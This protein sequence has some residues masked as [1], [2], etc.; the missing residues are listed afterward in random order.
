MVAAFQRV[1]AVSNDESVW[2]LIRG[3]LRSK[4]T[5]REDRASRRPR[6]IAWRLR[7]HFP[8]RVQLGP[9]PVSAG[10]K[11]KLD[12]W[13][14]ARVADRDQRR[15]RSPSSVKEGQNGPVRPLPRRRADK[16]RNLSWR[17]ASTR[18]LI[19]GQRPRRGHS[20]SGQSPEITMSTSRSLQAPEPAANSRR[21]LQ[22]TTIS[23]LSL[24]Q[25]LFARVVL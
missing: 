24:S 22:Q 18:N 21:R 9:R 25:R 1:V 6:S 14:R 20:P 7:E 10:S 13:I 16:V 11:K 15:P 2:R 4:L 23:V 17:K 5:I 8:R 12:E 19:T 3:I